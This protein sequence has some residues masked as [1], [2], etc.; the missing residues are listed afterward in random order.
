MMK[1]SFFLLN[2]LCMLIIFAGCKG[3]I[4][5]NTLLPKVRSIAL[6]Q[7]ADSA[8]DYT[9]AATLNLELNEEN[10]IEASVTISELDT[11]NGLD[12]QDTTLDVETS[13]LTAIND[14][15]WVGEI[16][17]SPTNNY[18]I[19]KAV[20]SFGEGKSVIYRSNGIDS[21]QVTTNFDD[22]TEDSDLKP[23]VHFPEAPFITLDS[24][25]LEQINVDQIVW[26]VIPDDY[27]FMIGVSFILGGI[28]ISNP[29]EFRITPQLTCAIDYFDENQQI[30][31]SDS[32]LS[33]ALMAPSGP[34]MV[35]SSIIPDGSTQMRLR[36]GHGQMHYTDISTATTLTIVCD[37]L[38]YSWDG[39]SAS[40]PLPTP[41]T[42]LDHYLIPELP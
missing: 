27:R 24:P 37:Q 18:F 34:A 31:A 5:G 41:L 11:R 4:I 13:A 21:Y 40:L 17:V 20:I 28:H 38:D 32:S 39:G 36:V 2:I 7:K 42:V 22:Y 25:A 3:T 15:R 23:A 33:A 29:D 35:Y 14:S 30:V 1:L 16:Q 26:H 10:V 6:E 19:S 9:L 8:S 12:Q